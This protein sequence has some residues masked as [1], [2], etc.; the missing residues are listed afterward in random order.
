MSKLICVEIVKARGH[1]NIKATHST[2]LEITKDPDLTPR[3]DCIIGVN[4]D[5]SA[6]DLSEDFKKCL[7]QEDTILITVIEVNKL[8]DLVLAEG[9]PRLILSDENKIILRKSN[10]I[11]PA[12]IGIKANKAARDIRRDIVDLLRSRETLLHVYFYVLSLN[13]ITS[14]YPSSRSIL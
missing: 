9:D 11:E 14:I 12:T 1:P 10:F 2:T 5:K 8:R 3:G 6:I 4:A 13:E 7:I